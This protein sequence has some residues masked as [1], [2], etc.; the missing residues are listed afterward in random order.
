MAVQVL[1]AV[2]HLLMDKPQPYHYPLQLFL[3]AAVAVDPVPQVLQE[4]QMAVVVVFHLNPEEQQFPEDSLEV[5]VAM[6]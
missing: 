3:L 6:A 5:V 2:L 4:Q 1:Q